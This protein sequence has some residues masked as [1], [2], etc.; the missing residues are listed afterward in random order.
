LVLRTDPRPV[1]TVKVDGAL[2]GG[3][4]ALK[5]DQQVGKYRVVRLLGAGG[6]GEVYLATDDPLKRDVA[7]KVM[8]PGVFGPDHE[9]VARDRLLH[10]AQAMARLAHPN[11]V[12]VFDAGLVDD[13]VYVAMEYVAGTTARGW[14]EAEPRTAKQILAMY[15]AA[16]RG[17][18]ALHAAKLVHRDVK[19][20]NVLVGEDGRPRIGDFGLAAPGDAARDDPAPGDPA[21]EREPPT[22]FTT[23]SR[24]HGG[25]PRYM[26]PEQHEQKPVDARGDQFSFCVALWEALAGEAP[27]PSTDYAELRTQVLAGTPID[28]PGARPI[29]SWIRAALLRGIA[30]RPEDR[31]PSMDALLETLERDPAARRKRVV[32]VVAAVGL[33]GAIGVGGIV[34]YSGTREAAA[35]APCGDLEHGLAG[36][37]DPAVS[38]AIHARFAASKRANAEAAFERVD[39]GLAKYANAWVEMRRDTCLATAVRKEQTEA[40]RDLRMQCLDRRA[41]ELRALTSVFATTAD[42][43]T[44]D[45]AVLAVNDLRP[46][47]SCA[48]A[49]SLSEIPPPTATQAPSIAPLR[50]RLDSV[51]AR[52]R[53]GQYKSAVDD[54]R[55][56]AADATKLGYAP[57]EA[58][59]LATLGALE[60]ALHETAAAEQHFHDAL[61]AAATAHDDAIAATVWRGLVSSANEL[62]H[63]DEALERFGFAAAAASR[64][65]NPPLVVAKLQQVGAEAKV[66]KAMYA[67]AIA[68]TDRA[69]ELLAQ[70]K[71]GELDRASVLNTRG[72]ALRYL[73]R[74]KESL[75]AFREALGIWEKALGPEHPNVAGVLLNVG[76]EEREAGQFAEAERDLRRSL[77]LNEK[78][79]GPDHVSV[80]RVA[81]SL[82]ETLA[83]IPKVDDAMPFCERAL[84]IKTK[85]SGPDSVEVVSALTNLGNIAEVRDDVVAARRYRERVV[86]IHEKA[87]GPNHPSV[88]HD[89]QDVGDIALAEGKV[90]EAMHLYERAQTIFASRKDQ[91]S[92]AA[93]VKGK[94]A[95][96]HLALHHIDAALA[97][98]RAALAGDIAATPDDKYTIGN[99]HTL[100]G[101]VLEEKRDLRGA[102]AELE[103]AVALV[104]TAMGPD[105]PA[106]SHAL[107][108]VGRIALAEHSAPDA[109]P[110]LERVLKVLGDVKF[111]QVELAIAQGLLAEALWDANR[112]RVR[113]IKLARTAKTTLDRAPSTPEFTAARARVTKWL[114]AHVS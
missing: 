18:S 1:V 9:H 81:N 8:R 111:G 2:R 92:R 28:S 107:T 3:S 76:N 98:A 30:L 22:A 27:F 35:P 94:I 49:K 105:T 4:G 63:Y 44:V 47:A 112:D 57:L 99:D 42:A 59:A 68:M 7:I 78:I 10:E 29:A 69:L 46:L 75:A 91:A 74:D 54:A 38:S 39:A 36:A 26:A 20:D 79:F 6:M 95:Q 87:L 101:L 84:A 14:L 12:V 15:I 104:E 113:A 16:G 58:E 53:G 65:G 25:T 96:A 108:A 93:G 17:L 37:W 97:G 85:A 80:G 21:P 43:T 110:P 11:V 19:P 48:N 67:E 51:I 45:R 109:I 100:I 61:A 72:V 24:V 83:Q 23:Y 34:L 88:A 71:A 90:D 114:A 33:A 70:A 73:S 56:V 32:A 66:K 62:A 41:D 55:A 60:S 64:A 103:Q 82:C 50:A 5:I 89:L 77:A 40:A 31:W 106:L 13:Q 52:Q 86:A 102:R